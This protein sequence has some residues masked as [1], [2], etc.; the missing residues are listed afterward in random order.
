MEGGK[1]GAHSTRPLYD[2]SLR[3]RAKKHLGASSNASRQIK[4]AR[5]LCPDGHRKEKTNRYPKKG[6]LDQRSLKMSSSQLEKSCW[7]DHKLNV[8]YACTTEQDHND[9]TELHIVE[10]IRCYYLVPAENAP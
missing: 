8:S 2:Y 1:Q 10:S 7:G 9:V 6:S 3:H 5:H 4:K